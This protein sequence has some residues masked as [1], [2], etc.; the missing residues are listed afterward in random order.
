MDTRQVELLRGQTSS[1][2]QMQNSMTAI[3]KRYVCHESCH[4]VGDFGKGWEFGC[5]KVNLDFGTGFWTLFWERSKNSS[6]NKLFGELLELQW[7]AQDALKA[8]TKPTC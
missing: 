7:N 5:N 1:V 3:W 8:T 2:V 6:L 4:F